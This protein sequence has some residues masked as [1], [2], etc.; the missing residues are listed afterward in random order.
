LRFEIQLTGIVIPDT[1]NKPLRS[2][3]YYCVG[4]DGYEAII[5]L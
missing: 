2:S 4:P 5:V 1:M 3:L